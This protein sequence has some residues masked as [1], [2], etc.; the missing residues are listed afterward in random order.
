VGRQIQAAP[1]SLRAAT[2]SLCTEARLMVW[3][4]LLAALLSEKKK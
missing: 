1:D 2:T 3:R 4:E